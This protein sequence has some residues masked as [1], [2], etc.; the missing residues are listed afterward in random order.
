MSTVFSNEDNLPGVI[1]E[2]ENDYTIGYDTSLFGTTDSV[3]VIGT[4]F[5]GPVGEAMPIYS[6]EHAKYVFGKTYDSTKRQEATLVA[7]VQDA[8]NRGCR[9]IYAVRVGGKELYKDFKLAIDNGFRLRVASRYPSNL[10]KQVFMRY[11]NTVGNETFSLYKPASRATIKEKKRGE[12]VSANAVMKSELRIGMDY[13]MGRDANLVDVIRLFNDADANNVMKLSIV[14]ENGVDVTDSTEAYAIPVGALFPGVYFIGRNDSICT[15]VTKTKLVIAKN[16]A[17]T[18]YSNFDHQYFRTLEYNTDVA[19]AYPIYFKSAERKNF[20]ADMLEVGITMSKPWDF[21]ETAGLSDRA[22]APDEID[23][24][25]TSLSTFETYKR[26]GN[27][28]AI[29]A[30]AI[31]RGKNKKGEP[32]P[33]RVTETP[34]DDQNRVVPILDGIYGS[35]EDA[36]IKYRVLTNV[37]ADDVISSKLPRAKDFETTVAGSFPVLKDAIVLTAKVDS[38]DRTT[39]RKFDIYFDKVIEGVSDNLADVYTDEVFPIVA[40]VDNI[41]DIVDVEAGTEVMVMDQMTGKG[42]MHRVNIAGVPERID[43]NDF[44]GKHYIVDG[45]VFE[46]ALVAGTAADIEYAPIAFTPVGGNSTAALFSG[47][48]YVLGET[49]DSVFVYQPQ[50]DG[51]IKPLGD[52]N[53]MLGETKDE[54]AALLVIHGQALPFVDNH[55]VV[56]SDS[57]ENMTI[58]ELVDGLNAHPIMS[59]LFTA[60][61]TEMGSQ[62]RDYMVDDAMVEIGSASTVGGLDV[63]IPMGEDRTIGYDFSKYIPYRTTDNFA[64]Q[65]AQHCT[66][67]E[68]KTTPTHGFIGCRRQTDVS[69]SAVAKRVSELSQVNFDLYAKNNYGRNMLDRNNYPYAIGKNISVVFGQYFVDMDDENYRFLSKGDAGYAGMVSTL[70]LDQSSTS[71]TIQLDSVTFRLTPSQLVK[72]TK[73]GIVTFKQSFTKGIVVTDGIT[74]APIDS[75]FRRLAA[76]RIMG[77]V[78]DLIRAAAEPFIGK[79]NHITN[80]NSLYTAIKSRL[81]KIKGTL[82]EAYEFNMIVDPK[83]LKFS[84]INID[85]TIVPVY[86]IREIRNQISVKDSLDSATAVVS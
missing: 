63:V 2:V 15:E 12:V 69:L 6:P 3:V 33:P 8:W 55:L 75:S 85:Y 64:R 36:E 27:G 10:G 18:P 59:K 38:E 1:T 31:D 30:K 51:S 50:A 74:M 48:E 82:I 34:M 53:T 44:V 37:A 67:T 66:Y 26:L 61:L 62:F 32:L 45:K 49:L 14:D 71:Q 17:N 83:L 46:G 86:E 84:Y 43:G 41:N 19:Q 42:Y 29:T 54:T 9:T 57:F 70:P 28:F 56:S 80:R 60:S 81:E 77:A 73:Q 58:G 21:L 5:D 79:Q 22:F 39:G 68:L 23:Y 7:G 4:A 24:E 78:E 20:T 35:L 47:K 13:G 72:M 65:L 16:A 40:H 52:L 11:D 76:W 25:E